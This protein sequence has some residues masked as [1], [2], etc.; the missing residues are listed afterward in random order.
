MNQR[1]KFID[2]MVNVQDIITLEDKT[3]FIAIELM[4]RFLYSLQT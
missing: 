4:D 2:W 1:A 3:F